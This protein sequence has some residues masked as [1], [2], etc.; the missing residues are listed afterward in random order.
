MNNWKVLFEKNKTTF[1]ESVYNYDL[2]LI[3][4]LFKDG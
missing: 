2:Y 3:C 1:T 4:G